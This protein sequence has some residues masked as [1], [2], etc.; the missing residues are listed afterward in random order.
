M[1]SSAMFRMAIPVAACMVL[2]LLSMGSPVMAD[3]QDDCRAICRPKCDELT[4]DVYTSLKEILP[5]ILSNLDAFGTSCKVRVSTLCRTFCMSVCT[6][7]TFTP[8]GAPTP[9][10]GSTAAPPPCKP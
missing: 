8:A 3:I 1:A 2:V 10:P 4:S 5:T 7:N 9:A 6:L